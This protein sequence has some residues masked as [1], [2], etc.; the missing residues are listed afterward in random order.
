MTLFTRLAITYGL[1]QDSLKWLLVL[2]LLLY[3]TG[4]TATVL[5]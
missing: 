5:L 1:L 4:G 3:G 2:A